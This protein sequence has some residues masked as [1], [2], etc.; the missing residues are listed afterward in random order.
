M[1]PRARLTVACGDPC[2]QAN[3]AVV[4]VLRRAARTAESASPSR[5]LIHKG[6]KGRSEPAHLPDL[7]PWSPP[8]AGLACVRPAYC[9]I[10]HAGE[11]VWSEGAHALTRTHARVCF[12]NQEGTD[13]RRVPLSRV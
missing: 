2:G 6:R 1:T 3:C 11:F 5:D 13:S 7:P 12:M 4:N 10:L 8:N 9:V